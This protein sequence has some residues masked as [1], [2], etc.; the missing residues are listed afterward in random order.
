VGFDETCTKRSCLGYLTLVDRFRTV[1]SAGKLEEVLTEV[2]SRFS[3]TSYIGI[4]KE[5]YREHEGLLSPLGFAWNRDAGLYLITW[6]EAL[7]NLLTQ[8]TSAAF[9]VLTRK[10]YRDKEKTLAPQLASG[11]QLAPADRT[12]KLKLRKLRDRL[13]DEVF[14][15]RA[16]N[17]ETF[18]FHISLAYQMS[19]FTVE[20]RRESQNILQHHIPIIVAAA[21]E[22]EFGV[23][24]F[25]TF[26]DM[27]RFEIR[28]LLRT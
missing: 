15:Y 22:M 19:G 13:A 8:G 18:G 5:S 12:E 9:D 7:E 3:T 27:Y 10:P 25:C 1:I 20:E 11:L 2:G 14:R 24:E 16:K 23:P 6:T 28:T 26:E 17:H 4:G 21:P